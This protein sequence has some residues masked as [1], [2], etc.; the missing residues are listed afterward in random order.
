M[1]EPVI[2]IVD[3]LSHQIPT[4]IAWNYRRPKI[5]ISKDYAVILYFIYV[6]FIS[7]LGHSY[8]DLYNIDHYLFYLFYLIATYIV[9]IKNYISINKA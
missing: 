8:V 1:E 4:V 5:V 3:I 7:L 2:Q 6:L 9:N